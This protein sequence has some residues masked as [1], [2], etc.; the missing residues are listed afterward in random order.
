MKAIVMR[1][2]KGEDSF[3]A[4]ERAASGSMPVVAVVCAMSASKL[5]AGRASDSLPYQRQS[6]RRTVIAVAIQAGRAGRRAINV[7]PL[8][9]SVD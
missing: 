7:G 9:R 2:T 8:P 5:A 4:D 6:G 3:A 1:A